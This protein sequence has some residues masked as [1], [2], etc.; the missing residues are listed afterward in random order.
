MCNHYFMHLCHKLSDVGS[1]K[2]VLGNNSRSLFLAGSAWEDDIVTQLW[3]LPCKERNNKHG[4][5]LRKLTHCF[6]ET[7]DRSAQYPER[8]DIWRKRRQGWSL[9]IPIG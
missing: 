2:L 5:A 9:P 1:F 3:S 7:I 8:N 4:F 6:I